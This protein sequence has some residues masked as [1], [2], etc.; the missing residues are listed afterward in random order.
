M[1]RNGKREKRRRKRERARDK[2]RKQRIREWEA[3]DNESEDRQ[4][5]RREEK[6]IYEREWEERMNRRRLD[7]KKRI[8]EILGQHRVEMGQI[9]TRILHEQQN[10]TNQLLGFVS[11]WTGHPTGLTDHTGAGNHYMSQM[12]QNLH[13]M[14]GIVHEDTRVEEDN[15]DDQFIVDG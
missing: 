15:Q 11:Q 14:N 3:M 4:R 10:L 7:W 13:Q 2:L 8:D 5:R 12:L 9:Q 6:L 1:K